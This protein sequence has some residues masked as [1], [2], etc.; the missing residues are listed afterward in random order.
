MFISYIVLTVVVPIA[1]NQ[2]IVVGSISKPYIVQAVI[3]SARLIGLPP[4][5]A[6]KAYAKKI[7]IPDPNIQEII[8]TSEPLAPRKLF[9]K[10]YFQQHT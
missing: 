6:A 1:I 4:S 9:F 7:Q 5:R 10:S 2:E 8:Y 3:D